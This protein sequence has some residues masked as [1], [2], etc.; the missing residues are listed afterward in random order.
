MYD[1]EAKEEDLKALKEAAK[2]N[3]EGEGELRVVKLEEVEAWGRE[4]VREAVRAK[5]EDVLCVMYTSGSSECRT[6]G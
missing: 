3:R 1:G 6:L 5:P 4:N 2:G